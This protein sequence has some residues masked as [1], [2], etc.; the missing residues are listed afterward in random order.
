M[1]NSPETLLKTIAIVRIVA[2][3]FFIF[4]G[5][6]KL[7][8]PGFVGGGFQQ[9]L[10]G[11]IDNGAVGFYS[12]FLA[13]V[14]LP[15]AVFFGYIIGLVELVVGL[16]LLLGF[17]VRAACVVGVLHMIS[18]T[19]ATWWEPGHGVPVWRYFGAQLDHIPLLMLLIVLYV[20]D[21]GQTWGLDGR[22][23]RG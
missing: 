16:C 12:R 10:Q 15:N 6:Y 2:A 21:A 5:Q 18:L 17:W 14:V 4:F 22:Q 9:Y 11:Y 1:R 23:G 19:L 20:A 7:F 8:S 3:F 13:Q